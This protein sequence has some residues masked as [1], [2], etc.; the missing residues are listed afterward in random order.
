MIHFKYPISSSGES[1]PSLKD[2]SS[3]YFDPPRMPFYYFVEKAYLCTSIKKSEQIN[4]VNLQQLKLFDNSILNIF[5]QRIVP[6]LIR[7]ADD[8][9]S[10]EAGWETNIG[11]KQNVNKY[12]N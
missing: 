5:N 8:L 11:D 3:G 12:I 10:K 6:S 2:F 9:T 4:A 1:N 7:L